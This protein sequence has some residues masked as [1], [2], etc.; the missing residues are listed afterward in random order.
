MRES[1]ER[2]ERETVKERSLEEGWFEP[3]QNTLEAMMIVSQ[4]H[5]VPLDLLLTLFGGASRR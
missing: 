3:L 2:E 5:G 1:T 4:V